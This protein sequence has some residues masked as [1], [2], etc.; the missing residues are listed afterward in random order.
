[1]ENTTE[2]PMNLLSCEM[3]D[4]EL[5]LECLKESIR[6]LVD[7]TYYKDEFI[8]TRAKEFYSFVTESK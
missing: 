8:T 5:R 6:S 3:T 1:M 2:Q 7:G 4:Q